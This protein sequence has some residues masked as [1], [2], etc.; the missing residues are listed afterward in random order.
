MSMTSAFFLMNMVAGLAT[1]GIAR[2]KK[3][4]APGFS[5]NQVTIGCQDLKLSTAFFKELGL[6]QIVDSPENGYARF[7]APNGSTLSIHVSDTP[8]NSSTFYF[9]CASLDD[10]CNQLLAK[11]LV[12]DQMPKDESWGWREARLKDPAGNLICLYWAGHYRRFP[13]WR[14]S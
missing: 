4:K 9:E 12:F 3:D 7:E 13:P 2:T 1:L 5:F 6:T 10:W 11:G 8:A 14:L